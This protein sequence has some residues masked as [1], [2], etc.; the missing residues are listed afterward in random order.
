MSVLFLPQPPFLPFPALS[1]SA[2]SPSSPLLL[3]LLL[4]LLCLLLDLHLCL[5]TLRNIAFWCS[6][7]GVHGVFHV[8]WHHFLASPPFPVEWST[9]WCAAWEHFLTWLRRVQTCLRHLRVSL[10]HG[11]YNG[12][13]FSP[14]TETSLKPQ[15]TLRTAC[16]LDLKHHFHVGQLRQCL[17]C[18][19]CRAW[20]HCTC[21]FGEKDWTLVNKMC[22][23][24]GLAEGK[25]GGDRA[26]R[27]G[28]D[29]FADYFG[30]QHAK[31]KSS[32]WWGYQWVSTQSR[33]GPQTTRRARTQQS[34][35]RQQPLSL[36]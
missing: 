12:S 23:D 27:Q 17:L 7:L 19:E 34:R 8:K 28:G 31:R 24:V 33:H 32:L 6:I 20:P 13:S 29:V 26:S 1:S 2:S 14:K 21:W 11:Q 36:Q 25:L 15:R 30:G 22:F 16:I 35:H 18:G 4:R 3:C 9:I 10:T 5:E